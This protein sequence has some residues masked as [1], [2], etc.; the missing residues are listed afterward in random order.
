MRI[1]GITY[2]S[3]KKR[4]GRRFI[5]LLF[6]LIILA[7]LSVS[8]ISVY[9]GWQVTH[10]P[11]R[12]LPVFSSNIVP[13]HKDV[14]FMDINNK[15]K[16]KGWLFQSDKSNKTVILAHGY[17]CNRLQF[18]EQSLDMIKRLLFEGYN[19]LTFDFR[20]SGTSGGKMTTVGYYEKDDILGAVDYIKSKSSN[21]IV[22]MG[23]SMG[24]AASLLAA[25]EDN[26]INAVIADSPFADLKQYLKRGL[27]LWIKPK[28]PSFPFNSTVLLSI[29]ILTG[30]NPASVSPANVIKSVSPAP[31]MLIHAKGDKVIPI[32]HSRN[33]YREYSQNGNNRTVL[34]EID[35]MDVNHME[36]FKK[37]PDKYM[38]K[39]VDFLNKN[40]K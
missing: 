15:V 25:S 30:I 37:Y 14:S 16:L 2:V 5:K 7:L 23:F 8:I 17:G 28:L 22:L 11:R 33:L 34:W 20:N 13:E 19:V 26:N 27:N 6:I 4:S 40:L 35:D 24:G 38:D 9:T 31:V 10:P 18:S 29:E 32:E 36:G 1:S 21:K 39:I 12:S 3:K